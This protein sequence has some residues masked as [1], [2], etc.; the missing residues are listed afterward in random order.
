[1]VGGQRFARAEKTVIDFL[2]MKGT[3]FLQER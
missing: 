1:M 2:S 3:P